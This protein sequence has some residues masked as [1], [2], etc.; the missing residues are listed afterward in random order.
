[1]PAR[2]IITSS[3]SDACG[4]E[5]ASD[6]RL[7]TNLA[8]WF[9]MTVLVDELDKERRLIDLPARFLYPRQRYSKRWEYA[10]VHS[11]SMSF[12]C[13]N[14]SLDSAS[15]AGLHRALDNGVI[16]KTTHAALRRMMVGNGWDKTEPGDQ[17]PPETP[18]LFEQTVYA[19]AWRALDQRIKGCGIAVNYRA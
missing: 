16:A 19:G 1:M 14:K 8:T 4:P 5:T 11:K 3:W 9:L 6:S 17:Y 10:A 2:V 12:T 18:R 7:L 15:A 13:S